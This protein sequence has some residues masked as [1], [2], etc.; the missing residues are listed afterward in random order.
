MICDKNTWQKPKTT[1]VYLQHP[2]AER[3]ALLCPDFKLLNLP[4]IDN[5]THVGQIGVGAI[6]LCGSDLEAFDYNET[7]FERV[8]NEYPIYKINNK[9]SFNI[10]LEAFAS[11]ERNTT[12]YFK[13]EITN[14]TDNVITDC[15]GIMPRS[16]QEKYMLNQHQEGYSPY[17]PNYKNWFM[18][19]RTWKN[20][21]ST[22]SASDI[23]FLTIN[24]Q[25]ATQKWITNSINGHSFSASDYFLIDFNLNVGEKATVYGALKANE[26]IN[27]FDYNT[28][29]QNSLL[30][31]QNVANNIKIKPNT[32]DSNIQ[33]IYRHLALQCMQMLSRYQDSD[34]VTTRQGDIGRFVWPYEGVQIL[35]QLDKIGLNDYTTDAYRCFFKRWFVSDGED[36]GKI[37]S[38]AG[39]ENFTG[40]VLWGVCQHLLCNK[41]KVEFDEFLPY[42]TA[43][44]DYINKK[45]N[46]HRNSGFN[47]IFPSG[48]GSDW[49]EI[50]QFWT[51]TDSHNVRA[52]EEA[53]KLLTLYNHKELHPTK[54]IYDEYYQVVC[55]IRDLLHSEHINDEAYILPHMLGQSFEDTENYSYYTDGAP[56]LLYTGF[57]L[58]GSKL[59][60]QMENFFVK[61]GQFQNGLTGRMTSCASMW[62]E[63][64]FG[65]YGDVWYTMQSETYWLKA[66]LACGEKEKAQKTLD[67]MLKY[68]MTDEFIVAERY[69][70]INP[71]YSPWQPNGSGSARMIEMILAYYNEIEC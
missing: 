51:F 52:L 62:D 48:K 58:P 69:C 57:I 8:E 11:E 67:A 15:I 64:Y 42:I 47:G 43:M 2:L 39:W 54:V 17:C 21:N 16:G 40:S 1:K 14:N 63:A 55:N 30:A 56:Y 32:D 38:N 59:M 10:S 53:V 27:K 34:L 3:I 19:K 49:S 7:N 50:G 66:W 61:R 35:M 33:I 71:W 26:S 70:S 46:L 68:G 12:I 6:V 60:R 23:G 65:G 37:F 9:S 36:K 20:I 13:I 25:N 31:W 4:L 5:S 29:R 24:C 18:L 44:R 22:S 45:R 41:S 28:E